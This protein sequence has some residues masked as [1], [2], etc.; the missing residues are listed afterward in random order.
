M[1]PL[2]VLDEP[3]PTVLIARAS[4]PSPQLALVQ[5][6]RGKRPKW[7]VTVLFGAAILIQG[8]LLAVGELQKPVKVAVLAELMLLFAIVLLQYR[9]G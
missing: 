7:F 4:S 1:A 3:P 9:S 2:P 6:P 8:V 5:D